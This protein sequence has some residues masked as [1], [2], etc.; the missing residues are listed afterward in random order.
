M[1]VLV[2]LL[3]GILAAGSGAPP[4]HRPIDGP[5]ISTT[6]QVIILDG[7]KPSIGADVG[8]EGTLV[9]IPGDLSQAGWSCLITDR[10]RKGT[11]ALQSIVCRYKQDPVLVKF[12]ATAICNTKDADREEQRIMIGTDKRA[13]GL[14]LRCISVPVVG[15]EI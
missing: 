9:P 4:A 12:S 6:F 10:L 14:V 3:A 15:A 2:V 11:V 7:D 8:P 1:N 5:L 13:V